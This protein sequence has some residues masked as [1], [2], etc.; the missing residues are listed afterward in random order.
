M[1]GIL[2]ILEQLSRKGIVDVNKSNCGILCSERNNDK[3]KDYLE[4]ADNVI[5]E[6]AFFQKKIVFMTCAY[7][8]GIDIQDNT[9][10]SLPIC[11][12]EEWNR[13]QEDVEMETCLKP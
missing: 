1:D 6:E 4:D 9:C 3:V 13:L 12:P 2:N 10:N 7:F 5:N 8:A 11:P